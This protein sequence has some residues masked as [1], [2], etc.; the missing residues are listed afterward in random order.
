MYFFAEGLVFRVC[1]IVS[2]SGSGLFLDNNRHEYND[3]IVL[4]SQKHNEAT[5]QVSQLVKHEIV[6]LSSSL[7]LRTPDF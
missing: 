2:E 6:T 3:T 1:R 5:N 4:C 7:F